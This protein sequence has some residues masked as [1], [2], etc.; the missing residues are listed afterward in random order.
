MTSP[1]RLR[2]LYQQPVPSARTGPLYNA[3]SYPTKIDAE[4]VALFI[5]THTRPGDTVLD[6]FGGSGTTAIA[7]KLCDRPTERLKEM[8]RKARLRPTWGPR[9]AVV[10]ELS[11]LGAL[12]GDVMANPPKPDEFEAAA[13][14]LLDSVES[15]LGWIYDA[16]SPT[17]DPGRIRHVIWSEVLKAPCCGHEAPLWD[18]AVTLS[19]VAVNSKFDCPEC[20]QQVDTSSCPRVT[21]IVHDQLLDLELKQRRR[22]PVRVY[23]ASESGNWSRP[24]T[25]DDERVL[26]KVVS[27]PLAFYPKAEI[28]WGDLY[29][30]GYHTGLTHFHHLYTPR[31]LRG[32]SAVWAAIERQPAAVQPA[33]RVWALSYNASHSTLLTRVVAK[34][35]QADFVIT[36]AQS[37]V[38][39]VSGLPVEKNV[40]QGLRRKI[41]TFKAAFEMTWGSQSTAEVVCGS[42]TKLHLA[43]DSVDYVFTDPP[44]GD[45]IPYAEV[46]QVNE[47]WL[48]ELTDRSEEAIISPAQ[49]KGVDDYATLMSGVF[50]EVA[51]ALRPTGWVTVVFHASK[52]AVWHALGQAFADAGLKTVRTSVLDKVQVSFKQV[53][54]EGGTRGDAVFLLR[55]GGA[56]ARSQRFLTREQIVQ[57][58]V[59]ANF[60]G[61]QERDRR[62][63][64]SR[65]VAT[66]VENGIEVDLSA[67]EFY[68]WYESWRSKA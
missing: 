62:R 8:A 58:I 31:N 66:C 17:G 18:L 48:G 45:F 10:Y 4:A 55:P 53:V 60:E 2:K 59:E 23:G 42:S 30:S 40:F 34:K 16:E 13:T 64:Y 47:A 38:L 32:L 56:P 44:F 50:S 67:P 25:A 6:V 68:E 22:V 35:N 15:E 21:D 24:I 11:P 63:V 26:D 5:A 14:A 52:P 9:H 7:A 3:F 36:G 20:G 19:P 41:S 57:Q 27:A 46:N 1:E 28:A 61:E 51:R 54:S 33:L 49:G 43:D 37:G 65:Y 39:Y 29:R 12:V